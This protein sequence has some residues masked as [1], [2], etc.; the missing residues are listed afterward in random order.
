MS[1]RQ[2]GV[3]NQRQG[4][5]ERELEEMVLRRRMRDIGRKLLVL[6]GKGGVGKSTVAANLAVALAKEGKRVGLLDVDVHGPSIPKLLG[7]SGER[8]GPH[9]SGGIRPVELTQNLKVVSVGFL[10]GSARDAVIWRGPMKHNLIR[11]FL[12]DVVWDELDY[13]VIDSPPGTGDEPLSVAKLVGAPAAAVVVTTPQD[14]AIADVRRCI[15]FCSA[16]SIP[17]LGIV[18]N[19]SG[20]VCPNC[21]VGVDLF[22]AGGGR[23]LAAEMNVPLLGRIPID[24]EIVRAGDAGRPFV[25]QH[26]R[27][28]S[29]KAFAG[30]VR[31]ILDGGARGQAEAPAKDLSRRAAP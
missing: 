16:L 30:V 28:A 7:L 17:V 9:S 21:G 10:L 6:S 3:H 29:A 22:G 23:K 25:E 27:R 12:M 2:E 8:L 18:E 13:L 11:Q 4:Q 19:M 1:S 14:L 26:G 31:R 5:T 15:S 24:P 20:F